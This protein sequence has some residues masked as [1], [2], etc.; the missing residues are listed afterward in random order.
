[1]KAPETSSRVP[2]QEYKE[3]HGPASQLCHGL[4]SGG[5]CRYGAACRF[6]HDVAAYLAVGHSAI[7]VFLHCVRRCLNP[8]AHLVAGHAGT[9]YFT[10]VAAC[11]KLEASSWRVA[12]LFTWLA[13]A[14]G[15]A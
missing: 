14:C 11:L 10:C 2:S 12:L 6:T 4:A 8:E 5:V 1:M 13:S 3:T 7:H 9:A 15:D